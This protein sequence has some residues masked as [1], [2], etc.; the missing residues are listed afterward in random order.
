MDIDGY[1]I[2]TIYSDHDCLHIL[3]QFFF[4]TA[5]PSISTLPKTLPFT[6]LGW[7]ECQ[8]FSAE[9]SRVQVVPEKFN[10]KPGA[11]KETK[12]SELSETINH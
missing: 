3:I 12:P 11:I 1:C 10:T 8:E 6:L 2:Y 7:F 9:I 5:S 4:L